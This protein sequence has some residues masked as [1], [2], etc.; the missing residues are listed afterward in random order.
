[1][2]ES[3]CVQSYLGFRKSFIWALP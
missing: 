1:L 3:S 2:V